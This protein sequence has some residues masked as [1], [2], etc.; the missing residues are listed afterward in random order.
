MSGDPEAIVSVLVRICWSGGCW[1]VVVPLVLVV[2]LVVPA[3]AFAAGGGFSDL[4]EAGPH[5]VGVERLAG[6]GVLDGTDCGRGEFCPTDALQ[7]WVMA[8]WLVR[9]LD[10]V[11]PVGSATRFADVA[12][13]WWAPFVERLAVLGVTAGCATSPAR[14]CPDDPVTRA[15]MATFL[16]RAFGLEPALSFGFVDVAGDTHAASIDALAGAG[17]TAGCATSPARYCPN[18]SVTRAQM[19][20]FLIRAIDRASLSVD[21]ESASGRA[22]AG[23]FQVGIAFAREV[24]SFDLGDVVVVNGRARG[25]SGSD[26]VYEVTVSPAAVGSVAVWIPAGAVRDA[27][28]IPNQSSGVLVRTFPADTYRDGPGFD[29]WDRAA[30]VASYVGEFGRVEPDWGYT[31]DVGG[32]VAGTTSRQFRDSVVQRVNWYRRMAGL[33]PVSESPALSAAAQDKALIMLAEGRLSHS[34]APD[35]ACY[36]NIEGPGGENLGLGTAGLLGVDGYIR[37]PGDHNLAVGHR[38]QILSPLVTEIGVGNVRTSGGYRFAN[39]MHLVYDSDLD[40]TVREERG[41][42][43]WPPAGYVPAGVVWGRW[44]FS[45]QWIQTEVTRSGNVTYTRWFLTQPD[46]SDAAVSVTDDDGAVETMII[47]RDT[48]LVWAVESDTQSDLL[49]EPTGGDR[50]YTVT[51]SGVRENTTVQTPYEYAVCVLG[52]DD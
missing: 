46:F 19:A 34:P 12:D 35:W 27:A 28:G 15:Q 42:V 6:V 21:L 36:R 45:K 25:L 44:S 50:C 17:V 43:A 1:R 4:D 41:F 48:A 8:V 10:G 38:I 14:Y 11:D 52:P 49:D 9:V 7:R 3:G 47:H 31:G 33:D 24:A 13:E 20:T 26:S 29:V 22:V 40:P 18:D 51:I 16:T 2:C 5:R 30:V 37:D 32:C 39:A 23:S